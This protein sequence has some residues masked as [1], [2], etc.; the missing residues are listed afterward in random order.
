MNFPTLK[1]EGG[2]IIKQRFSYEGM[3]GER[4]RLI[5]QRKLGKG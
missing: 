5:Y 2:F 1:V 4:A 3:E